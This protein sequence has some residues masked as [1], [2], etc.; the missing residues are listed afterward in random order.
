MGI[1]SFDVVWKLYNLAKNTKTGVWVLGTLKDG[2]QVRG[3]F[4]S[5]SFAS[6]EAEERDLF[7][8]RRFEDDS[9]KPIPGSDGILIMGS[10][11]KHVEFIYDS[12]NGSLSTQMLSN[13]SGCSP[14]SSQP[15]KSHRL[16][17]L[18]R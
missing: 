10:E 9:W 1:D 17:P 8:Q 6:S 5:N 2:H 15:R 16:K 3:L 11:I 7:L 18:P 13:S 14:A 4:G 12:R